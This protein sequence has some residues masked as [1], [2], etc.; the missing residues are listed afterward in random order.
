LYRV[1][2]NAYFS[3]I[4]QDSCL[5]L[6]KS[7]D[8]KFSLLPNKAQLGKVNPALGYESHTNGDG[9]EFYSRIPVPKSNAV[10]KAPASGSNLV[11][12]NNVREK[13]FHSSAAPQRDFPGGPTSS[14][15]S[16]EAEEEEYYED[17][18]VELIRRMSSQIELEDGLMIGSTTPPGGPNL[19]YQVYHSSNSGV[20]PDQGAIL[21][22]QYGKIV[23]AGENGK[24][25][26]RDS[27]G[28]NHT[29]DSGVSIGTS[30]NKSFKMVRANAIFFVIEMLF[31]LHR[32]LKVFFEWLTLWKSYFGRNSLFE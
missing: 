12:I 7:A 5:P 6:K 11:P 19:E 9:P 31:G 26:D 23:S 17:Q 27:A 16:T 2:Q 21:E 24:K 29:R 22:R 14:G 15:G 30:S 32:F 10:L 3:N 28:S 25:L 4:L 8:P 1:F 18:D 13:F 20:Q